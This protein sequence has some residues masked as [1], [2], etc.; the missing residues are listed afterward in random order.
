MSFNCELLIQNALIEN[1]SGSIF[2]EFKRNI[3]GKWSQD[4]CMDSI[5]PLFMSEDLFVSG[6]H[7]KSAI[8]DMGRIICCCVVFAQSAKTTQQQ[9]FSFFFQK[10]FSNFELL[11]KNIVIESTLV[12]NDNQLKNTHQIA[13]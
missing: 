9:V 4:Y 6:N 7:K 13:P 12:M 5:K 8:Q 10:A 11:M 1:D 2:F 3:R